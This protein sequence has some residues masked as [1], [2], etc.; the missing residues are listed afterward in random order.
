M[1]LTRKILTY[2]ILSFGCLSGVW[3]GEGNIDLIEVPPL[4][5]LITLPILTG[6]LVPYSKPKDKKSIMFL[7]A[8]VF[9][10]SWS[11]GQSSSKNAFKDCAKQ[12]STI[13][14]SIEKYKVD[15]GYYP[16]TLESLGI[17]LPGGRVTRPSILE[18][19]RKND[20]YLVSFTGKNYFYTATD[21]HPFKGEKIIKQPK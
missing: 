21:Q 3:I 17:E 4:L 12:A 1:S 11:T 20:G 6:A 10:V 18:Y 15:N 9:I 8:V 14:A 19:E 2:V 5:L 16:E 7:T 13:Q